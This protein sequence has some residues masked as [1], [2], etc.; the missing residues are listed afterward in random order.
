MKPVL[1]D[2]GFIVAR[3][4]RSEKFHGKCLAILDDLQAP[5]ITC[6]A[7][8]VES[9]HLLS[10]MR[11]ARDAIL[12]N[13]RRGTLQVPFRLAERAAEVAT[14]LNKYSDVPMDL[15]DACLV[16][17]ATQIGNGQILT[18]DS[19]FTIFRWGRR[20]E[21]ELLIELQ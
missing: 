1:V 21:F 20:R 7:V 4:D 13:V 16:D 3:L 6:E 12:Q 19:D 14:L 8:I 11:G 17:L 15:A 5:L 9:C 18:L 2:T 10:H